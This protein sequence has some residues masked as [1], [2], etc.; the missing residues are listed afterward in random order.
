MET[1]T[2]CISCKEGKYIDGNECMCNVNFY[3]DSNGDCQGI[4]K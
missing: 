4:Y 1:D 2:K 3:K